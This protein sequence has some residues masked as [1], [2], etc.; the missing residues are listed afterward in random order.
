MSDKS[1]PTKRGSLC[2]SLAFR[3]GAVVSVDGNHFCYVFALFFLLTGPRSS[4]VFAHVQSV[5]HMRFEVRYSWVLWVNVLFM[6]KVV[7]TKFFYAFRNFG[8]CYSPQCRSLREIKLH[9]FGSLPILTFLK[10]EVHLRDLQGFRCSALPREHS[11]LMTADIS[12]FQNSLTGLPSTSKNDHCTVQPRRC[13]RK[14][15][16]NS[17]FPSKKCKVGVNF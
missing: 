8:V 1:P 14:A 10:C 16:T 5:H 17:S 9:N 3:R 2:L 15:N 13:E 12:I 7:Q 11:E 4:T 6:Y